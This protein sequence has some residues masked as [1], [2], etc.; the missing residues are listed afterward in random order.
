MFDSEKKET[1]KTNYNIKVN[2]VRQTKNDSVLMCDITVNGVKIYS[3]TFKE[4]T[5][6]NGGSKYKKGD[7]C[8][9]LGMPHVKSGDKY[10][11]CVWFPTSNEIIE[12]VKEQIKS[13]LG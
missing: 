10:Y 7:K 11:E 5:V 8:Y 4:V 1:E 9:F 2:A 3:C 6:K 13:L 12:T